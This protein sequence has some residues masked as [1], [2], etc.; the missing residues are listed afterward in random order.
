MKVDVDKIRKEVPSIAEGA[1]RVIMNVYESNSD[2]EVESKADDSPLTIA[3]RKANTYICNKL[4]SLF[5][6]IPIISEENKLIPYEQRKHY[7]WYWLIDPLDGTK[8]FIKRNG[9]F[10]V[11]IALVHD[12]KPYYGV[13][14]APALGE[15]YYG[16]KAF[17]AFLKVENEVKQLNPPAFSMKQKGLK[18]VCSRSHFSEETKAFL[19]R[20]DSPDLVSKG[21]SFKF[22]LLATG[23]AHIYPRL[24]PTMEWDTAAAQAVLEAAG[25]KVLIAESGLPV[26]YNKENLLNP[27]FIAYGPTEE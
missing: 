3:D 8:E 15:T 24:A 21:S 18:A 7:S 14:H 10:T 17:G 2:W 27:Y 6:E 9:E 4:A 25:G 20:L 1:G 13:V 26:S 22:L 5:P 11:N 23:Q 12:G 16:G 19:N